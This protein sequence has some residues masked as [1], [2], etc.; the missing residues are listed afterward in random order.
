LI[1]LLFHAIWVLAVMRILCWRSTISTR[2]MLTYVALGTFISFSVAGPL[3]RAVNPYADASVW[4]SFTWNVAQLALELLPLMAVLIGKAPTR[5]LSVADTFL[6]AFAIG[7]GFDLMGA[8]PSLFT[9]TS[10]VA[11]FNLL[12]PGSLTDPV[13]TSGPVLTMAGHGLW[14]GFVALAIVAARRFVRQW[15]AVCIAAL[16]SLAFCA[17]DMPYLWKAPAFAATWTKLSHN[18]VYTGWLIVG[19]LVVLSLLELRWCGDNQGFGQILSDWLEPVQALLGRDIAGYARRAMQSQTRR[20]GLIAQKEATLSPKL[21]PMLRGAAT[22]GSTPQGFSLPGLNWKEFWRQAWFWQLLC[23]AALVV[24]LLSP[25]SMAHLLF[26]PVFGYQIN[27]LHEGLLDTLLVLFLLWRFLT[28]PGSPTRAGVDGTLLFTAEKQIFRATLWLVTLGWLFLRWT[29]WF[30]YPNLFVFFQA[31]NSTW[32]GWDSPTIRTF[33]LLAGVCFSSITMTSAREWTQALAVKRRVALVRNF[34]LAMTTGTLFYCSQLNGNYMMYLENFFQ[35]HGRWFYGLSVHLG[36]NGNKLVGWSF[37]LVSALYWVPLTI[38]LALLTRAAVR[39]FSEDDK[40]KPGKGRPSVAQAFASSGAAIPLAV[41][42]G[43]HTLLRLAFPNHVLAGSCTSAED[44][45]CYPS[46]SDEG[47]TPFVPWIN[48]PIVPWI[49]GPGPDGDPWGPEGP[50]A[51]GGDG[52]DDPKKPKKS[53]G[54][55]AK[56]IRDAMRQFE[57]LQDQLHNGMDGTL[58]RLGQFNDQYNNLLNQA[59]HNL[60]SYAKTYQ[61]LMPD[62]QEI[63]DLASDHELGRKIANATDTTLAVI[64]AAAGIGGIGLGEDLLAVDGLAGGKGLAPLPPDGPLPPEWMPPEKPPAPPLPPDGPLPPE[65]MPPETP[66]PPPTGP[67]TP[68]AGPEAPPAAPTPPT[69]PAPPPYTPPPAPVTESPAV[70][71][72]GPPGGFPGDPRTA[73]N[74]NADPGKMIIIGHSDAQITISSARVENIPGVTDVNLH[75]TPTSVDFQAPGGSWQSM[76]APTLLARM[77]ADGYQMGD[78]VRLLACETGD[79]AVT[80]NMAQ[81]LA[82]LTGARVSAPTDIVNVT[83]DGAISVQNGGTFQVYSPR[84]RP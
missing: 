59:L 6:S 51:T 41:A 50:A 70:L 26:N 30:P 36:T 75:G 44:C 8:L 43:A 13:V 76:D 69:T 42:A 78:P 52:G 14:V 18:G 58:D 32:P 56:E 80:N 55:F 63:L 12:P 15:W 19:V 37:T 64:Q 54:D 81:Q 35:A 45:I 38:V 68:P 23:W 2:T 24:V 46:G 57:Q 11:A 28:S 48:L 73:V 72:D 79:P 21:A 65:W 16:A 25:T 60:S 82:D 31:G 40:A 74:P 62:I 66:P 7:F 84:P 83:R 9:P 27:V 5:S 53:P 77:Q 1:A 29:I 61:N 20:R 47:M 4:L 71:P 17:M 22:P 39:L 49:S 10:T 3:F 33:L 34:M 67:E